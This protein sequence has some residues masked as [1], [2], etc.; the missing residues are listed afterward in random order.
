MCKT[1]RAFL[2]SAP[3]TRA[4]LY[5]YR[6]FQN[7]FCFSRVD[8]RIFSAWQRSDWRAYCENTLCETSAVK[9]QDRTERRGRCGRGRSHIQAQRVWF[10]EALPGWTHTVCHLCRSPHC[11]STWGRIVWMIG[12]VMMIIRTVCQQIYSSYTICDRCAL[13]RK[14]SASATEV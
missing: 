3:Q 12:S 5:L 9:H 11:I 6:R 13:W 8:T 7:L 2:T 14:L 10:T 1:R 4:A